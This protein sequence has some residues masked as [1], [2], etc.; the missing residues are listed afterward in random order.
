MGRV[1]LC[2]NFF[3]SSRFPPAGAI[4]EDI[5]TKWLSWSRRN[6]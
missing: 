4:R 1:L 5:R 3:H 6:C 2:V